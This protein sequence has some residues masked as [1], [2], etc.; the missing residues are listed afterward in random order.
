DRAAQPE[1]RARG[2]AARR[3]PDLP[4]LRPSADDAPALPPRGAARTPRPAAGH[5]CRCDPIAAGALRRMD[6]DARSPA[7]RP[8]NVQRALGGAGTRTMTDRAAFL[9]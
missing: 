6:P 9:G 2:G 7:G 8:A 3:A 5:P 1:R 4:A